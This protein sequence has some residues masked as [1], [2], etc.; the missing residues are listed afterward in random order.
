MRAMAYARD[1]R[2]RQL[3]ELKGVDDRWPLF[4]APVFKPAQPVRDVLACED[5]GV[6]GAA[7][8]QTLLDR[9]HVTRGE[10]ID[11]PTTQETVQPSSPAGTLAFTVGAPAAA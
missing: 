2:N 6:C 11:R 7:A 10:L 9:L 4:G 3:V 8:E 1:N 5:D